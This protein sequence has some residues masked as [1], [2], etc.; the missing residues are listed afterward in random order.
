MFYNIGPW[1]CL[2]STGTVKPGKKIYTTRFLTVICRSQP[3]KTFLLAE[4]L[5][6]WTQMKHLPTIFC[7]LEQLIIVHTLSHCTKVDKLKK[8]KEIY[9]KISS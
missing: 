7:K 5:H 1:Y 6:Y 2:V 3:Y 4:L 9:T 8:S